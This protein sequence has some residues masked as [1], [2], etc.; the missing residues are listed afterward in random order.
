MVKKKLN[1][2]DVYTG[3]L[4][5]LES[6]VDVN[7]NPREGIFNAIKNILDGK[8]LVLSAP[9]GY[10]KTMIVYTL[11]YFASKGLGPFAPRVIHVLPL[12]SIIDDCHLR[13]FDNDNPKISELSH[14]AVAR[15]MMSAHESPWLQ[16]SLI[17]TT[18]DTFTYCA[19]R[20]PPKEKHKITGGRTL[21]H[22]LYTKSA[23]IS[24]SIV[25][26]EV[27][28]FLEES[29]RLASVLASLLEWLSFL[30]SPMVIMSA[31]LP[32]AFEEF[33]K[34]CCGKSITVLR[35]GR[36]FRDQNF[37]EERIAKC[38][39]TSV[40]S[41]GCSKIVE[42]GLEMAGTYNR[43]LITTNTVKRCIAVAHALRERGLNPVILH[44]KIA[45]GQRDK[46]LRMLNGDKWVAVTTQVIEAGVDISADVLISDFASPCSLVQRA[47]RVLR[48]SKE[49]QQKGEIIIIKD[50]E[51]I[52]G[53]KA[54]GVYDISLT[55]ASIKFLEKF[56]DK[57][58]WHLP[59]VSNDSLIG[60]EK[61]IEETYTSSGFQILVEES[62]RKNVF[63]FL[64]RLSPDPKNIQ[65]FIE[66]MEGTITRDSPLILGLVNKERLTFN[67]IIDFADLQKL[68]EKWAVTLN[69]IDCKKL[70]EHSAP[71]ISPLEKDGD[72]FRVQ[73]YKDISRKRDF[74]DNILRGEISAILIPERFY[75]D[76]YGLIL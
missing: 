61:F 12:R 29:T 57:L 37:E 42:K 34:G 67:Q 18:I 43:V 73:D 39:L 31:T 70:L 76:N 41:G 47:G 3:Y 54:Y 75:D 60:Y 56:G 15:Q 19:L 8:L 23:I 21:G 28:L 35:Y 1:S 24:S 16:K 22:G 69:L 7:A 72:S 32:K 62:V 33:V 14:R 30:S 44:G 55:K 17:F 5:V 58:T 68:V 65:K 40:A 66:E 11:G 38:L 27:Q 59:Y 46:R 74:I 13:L 25:F 36:D 2:E 52:K 49:K 10:G 63:G 4:R 9:P 48:H 51:T 53:D 64:L 71:V 45:R 20:L 26:D 50:K 6:L